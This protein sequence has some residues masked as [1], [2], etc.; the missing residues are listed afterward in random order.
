MKIL[1]SIKDVANPKSPR[2]SPGQLGRNIKELRLAAGLKQSAFVGEFISSGYISLIEQGK[3]QPSEQALEHIAR[4]LGVATAELL[5]PKKQDLSS[6][7][8]VQL[9][10]IELHLANLDIDAAQEIHEQLPESVKLSLLCRAMQSEIDYGKGNFMAAELACTELM[11][12]ALAAEDW[13][14]LRRAILTF[15]RIANRLNCLLECQIY[16]SQLRTRLLRIDG[17]DVLLMAQL[18]A[19]LADRYMHLGD[20]ASSMKLLTNLEELLP[21]VLDRR[22]LGSALW[23]KSNT[24]FAAGDYERALSLATEAQK[25]FAMESDEVSEAI[26]HNLRFSIL[27]NS[28]IEGDSILLEAK[29]EI[30]ALLGSRF[31]S[32]HFLNDLLLLHRADI[33][34]KLGEYQEALS[35][36]EYLLEKLISDGQDTAAIYSQLAQIYIKLDNHELAEQ[37]LE[38]S[39]DLIKDLEIDPSMRRQIIL[40]AERFEAVGNS[41]LAIKTL[42]LTYKQAADFSI[43]IKD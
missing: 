38:K 37:Y 39:L 33:Q 31:S 20:T 36:Y 41:Q 24:A 2:I 12:D 17:V 15:G 7:V 10:N 29:S 28:L 42:K 40:L 21:K 35:T 13:S 3:R 11:E 9:A 34:V 32:G 25:Y 26:L 1:P 23:A 18:T 27:K 43:M 30:D 22:G 4:I 14:V 8:R 5:E 19:S 16:L 6:Q